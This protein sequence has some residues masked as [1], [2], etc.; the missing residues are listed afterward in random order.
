[1]SPERSPGDYE[2]FHSPVCPHAQGHTA[3]NSKY[4]FL[5]A[6]PHLQDKE[7]SFF[8]VFGHQMLQA[9]LTQ[10]QHCRSRDSESD[11]ASP[12]SEGV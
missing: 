1:M 6:F 7:P 3:M 8:C 12:G 4:K 10:T 5:A 9:V 2:G 11:Y